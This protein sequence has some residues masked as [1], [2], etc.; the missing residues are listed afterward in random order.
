MKND[1]LLM[2]IV[3]IYERRCFKNFENIWRRKIKR[4]GQSVDFDQA[5]TFCKF[6]E[7]KGEKIL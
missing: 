6:R 2:K 1:I 7:E 3:L 5:L 4:Q